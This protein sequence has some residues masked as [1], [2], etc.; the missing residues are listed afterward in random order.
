MVSVT[1]ACRKSAVTGILT[2]GEAETNAL[3]VAVGSTCRTI[4][5]NID[6]SNHGNGQWIHNK[7]YSYFLFQSINAYFLFIYNNSIFQFI[8]YFIVFH[9]STMSSY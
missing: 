5:G 8:S 6:K 9:K 4:S 1:F 3:Y 7:K 2:A